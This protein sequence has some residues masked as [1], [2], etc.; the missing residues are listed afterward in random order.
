MTSILFKKVHPDAK[1]PTKGTSG[2]A[3]H[4]LYAATVTPDFDNRTITVD[5]G[6]QTQ[7]DKHCGLFVF[8]RSGLSKKHGIR[9]TNGV[10]VID[11]DYRGNLLIIFRIEDGRMNEALSILV[12]G[13]RV[14]QCILLPLLMENWIEVVELDQTD[15]GEGGFGSSGMT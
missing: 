12:P 7:F 2:A 10:G 14:A 4:D 8:S 13:A 15:R 9:L 1:H 11:S 5:T 6:L 3:A